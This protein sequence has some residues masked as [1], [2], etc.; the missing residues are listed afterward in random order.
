[1][2]FETTAGLQPPPFTHTIYTALVVP[3]PIGWISTMSH[4]GIINL[5]PYSFFN[6]VS[7]D[8]PCVMYCP[9]GWKPGT[10][11]VKDS[12]TNVEATGEFVFNMCTYALREQMNATAAHVPASV[13]E[14][15]AA[16]LE[17]APCALVKPP[18]VKAS[19]IALEC[20]YM[21]TVH[22][23]AARN[24]SPNNIVIGQVIG[25]HVADD[26]II[27]GRIDVHKINPLARLGYLDYATIDH[28][29]ALTR[30]K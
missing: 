28:V 30:P 4:T 13:D 14:M 20:R 25:I 2:F 11:E 7:G 29:F 10:T 3:R 6:A 21:Q 22:L 26:V 1:M 23:P 24:G 17:A 12:L 27:D 19:P 5:A 15:A 8:P 9:N 16:G 18:R